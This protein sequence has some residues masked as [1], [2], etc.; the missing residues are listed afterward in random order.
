MTLLGK[1]YTHS[2]F[3]ETEKLRTCTRQFSVK[4]KGKIQTHGHLTPELELL[5]T[6]LK[7]LFAW[8]L[9]E[10]SKIGHNWRKFSK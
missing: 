3:E 5:T 4:S 7:C 2:Q 1:Y 8:L 6:M 10:M 9:V